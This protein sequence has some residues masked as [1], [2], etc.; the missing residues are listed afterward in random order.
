MPVLHGLMRG[1]NMPYFIG[2]L[3]IKDYVINIMA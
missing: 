3:R 2:G 1:M